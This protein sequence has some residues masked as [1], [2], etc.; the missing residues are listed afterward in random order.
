[1]NSL[2]KTIKKI[3]YIF[4]IPLFFC[5]PQVQANNSWE[6]ITPPE[7][8]GYSFQ[9]AVAIDGVVF[10]GT[11]HGVYKSI[12][13]GTGWTQINTGLTN[14]NIKDI[15]IQWSFNGENFIYETNASTPVFVGTS[16]GFF[17]GTLGGS[18]W[19]ISNT[20]LSSTDINDIEID[21]WDLST[22]YVATSDGVFRSDDGGDAWTIKDSGMVGQSV[23]KLVSAFGEG[24]EKIYALTTSNDLYVSVLSSVSGSDE[25]W[26]LVQN[27]SDGGTMKDIA[28]MNANGGHMFL[29]ETTG[30]RK[31][32]FSGETWTSQNQGLTSLSLNSVATDYK[33]TGI[34]YIA[35]ANG[36][37]ARSLTADYSDIT[38][39]P[40]N[41]NL[42]E[43]NAKRVIT[44][45][46]TSEI[47]YMVGVGGFYRIIL[48]DPF[49][50]I[51]SPRSTIT[52]SSPASRQGDSL[53]INVSFDELLV[54]SS[55]V[56]LSLSGANTLSQVA[57]TKVDSTHY[58]YTHVIGAG[59]GALEVFL[60]RAE[61]VEGENQIREVF[62]GASSVLTH[63]GDINR[64]RVVDIF[65]FNIFLSHFGKNEC[66]N[67]GD[68][69]KDCLVNIFDF[70]I[71]LS[72]FGKSL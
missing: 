15:A 70:N 59:T 14:Q 1:M 28:V 46:N 47:V 17:K 43:S 69:N 49:G 72:D 71:F 11:N 58:S 61:E 53:S 57:M 23:I 24:S 45:P 7:T 68:V 51:V 52:F 21:Q 31:S 30:M 44:N 4:F 10:L 18:S 63:R 16:D 26:T 34:A 6:V 20:G 42:T 29:T 39:E 67:V 9:T 64:N 12:N 48:D 33:D 50:D 40:I 37:V 3:K 8:S 2:Q 19:T 25:E 55:I 13:Q 5:I 54:E 22:L 66:D 27:A 65:D 56:L 36:G 60:S 38:W 32:D 35:L 41:V 62:A